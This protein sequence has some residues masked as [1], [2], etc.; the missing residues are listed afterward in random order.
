[1]ISRRNWPTVAL[2][3]AIGVFALLA[4]S[5][6][7]GGNDRTPPPT[8]VA[9]PPPTVEPPPSSGGAGASSCPLGEGTDA[10]RCERAG[11]EMWHYVNGAIDYVI[12]QHPEYFNLNMEAGRETGQ[13]LVL[14]KELYIDAVLERLRETGL[15]AERADYDYEMIQI[16]EDNELSE[17]YDIYLSEGYVRRGGAYRQSCTPASFPVPRPDWAPPVG[18]GCGKPYPPAIGRFGLN[19][20]FKNPEYWTLDSTP[21]VGHDVLY[22]RSIG[23]TDGRSLCPVRPEGHPEREACERWAVG[24]AADTGRYGPTWTGDGQPCT[25]PAMGCKNSPDSQY[26]LF[27]YRTGLYEACAQNQACGRLHV[28]MD[29]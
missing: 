28:D 15:C 4:S 2:V 8:A 1:M 23:F 16:K 20:H 14:E 22:C 13:Y 25:G 10:T 6:G 18:S 24:R 12:G 29:K 27:I 26:L 11:A 17:D 9:P 7:D 19:V 3:A 21:L 5:C